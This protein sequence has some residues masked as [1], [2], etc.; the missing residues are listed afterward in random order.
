MPEPQEVTGTATPVFISPDQVLEQAKAVM[1]DG[2]EPE[3]EDDWSLILNCVAFNT[4]L[5]LEVEVCRL[6]ALLYSIPLDTEL[7]EEIAR[8]QADGK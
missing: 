6:M 5:G 3:T 2:R 7:V 8:F 1:I 4:P